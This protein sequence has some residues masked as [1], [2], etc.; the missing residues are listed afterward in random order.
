MWAHTFLVRI[1]ARSNNDLILFFSF[2][3]NFTHTSPSDH[4]WS[5]CSVNSR[6]QSSFQFQSVGVILNPFGTSAT[7]WPIVSAPDDRWW[8]LWSTIGRQN[9]STR[10]KS[11]PMPLCSSQIPHDLTWALP[12]AAVMAS[13]RLTAWAMAQPLKFI[14]FSC[15]I[16]SVLRSASTEHHVQSLHATPPLVRG[17]NRLH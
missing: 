10:R 2:W 17:L 7:I 4:D 8:W 11:A 9:R 13:W 15:F 12:R 5:V 16:T 6:W 1:P 14:W 3:D